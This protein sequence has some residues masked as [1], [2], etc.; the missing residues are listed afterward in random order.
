M[1]A[2]RTELATK[3]FGSDDPRAPEVWILH[4]ILGSLRNWRMPAR[5]LAGARPGWRVVVVDLRNH[6]DSPAI[7]GDASV[8]A[9]VD[10]LV[11]LAA[12][13]GA[14]PAVVV[15][16]SYGGKIALA[17]GRRPLDGLRGVVS[18]DSVASAPGELPDDNDVAQVFAA[19]EQAPVPFESRDDLLQWMGA[20]GFS[21]GLA[22]W[23]STNLERRDDGYVWRFDLAGARAMLQG[24][25][26]DDLWPWLEDPTVDVELVMAGRGA[27]WS[28]PDQ[29]MAERLQT[30]GRLRFTV[31][32]GAGHWVHVEDPEGV[33]A[34]LT[35]A[36]DRAQRAT[37]PPG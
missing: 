23:M 3:S 17:C 2:Q 36:V 31:L 18:L 4:G 25:L 5:R 16:H 13:R 32:E 21:D 19:L 26:E 24:Y 14:G 30:A 33:Q 10:D 15:G 37:R 20:R 34:I 7:P 9:V 11:A 6:G 28:G 35:G 8:E 12:S 1:S 27:R 22:A 29:A